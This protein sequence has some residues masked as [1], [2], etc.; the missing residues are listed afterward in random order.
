[1]R[2]LPPLLSLSTLGL[3][4]AAATA[5][6]TG[7]PR[8]ARGLIALGLEAERIFPRGEKGDAVAPLVVGGKS[9]VPVGI[10]VRPDG[11]VAT[12]ASSHADVVAI[13]DLEQSEIIGT[14]RAGQEPDGLGLSQRRARAGER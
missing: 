6:L 11:R 14:L 13:L 12:I 7:D 5:Q 9:S 8:Q 4:W 2:L 10:V 3:P 1:M